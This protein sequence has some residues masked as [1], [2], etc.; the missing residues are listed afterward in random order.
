MRQ[1]RSGFGRGLA[2][3]LVVFALLFAAAVLLLNRIDRASSDE[4]ASLVREAVRS[5]L[6]TC[7]AVEGSYPADVEYLK[8]NYGLAYD[9]GRYIVDCDAF[10]SNVMPEVRVRVRGEAGL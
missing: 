1:E 4:Q 10:A 2:L 6:V 8:E 7:Y 5:A 3:T 9:G